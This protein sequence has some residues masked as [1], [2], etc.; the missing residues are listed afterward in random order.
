LLGGENFIFGGEI[1]YLLGGDH[2]WWRD[3][4]LVGR[5]PLLVERILLVGRRDL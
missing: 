4:L 1:L 2:C 3:F 5:R